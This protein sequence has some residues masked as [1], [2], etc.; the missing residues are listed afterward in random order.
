MLKLKHFSAII[1]CLTLLVSSTLTTNIAAQLPNAVAG[2]M[3]VLDDDGAWCWY[4]DE[5]AIIVDDRHVLIGAV[6]AGTFDKSRLG[7]INI[8]IHDLKE[9]STQIVEL[10]DQLEPDDHDSPALL[11]RPDGRVL[12]VYSM[13]GTD[14][15]IRWRWTKE[16]GNLLDWHDEQSMNGNDGRYNVSYSNVEHLTTEGESGVTY[17]FFRGNGWN[18]TYITSTDGGETWSQPRPFL[19]NDGR[20]Y[21]RYTSNDVDTIHVATSEQHPRNYDNSIYHGFIRAGRLHQTDGNVIASLDDAPLAVTELTRVFQGSPDAVAWASD[22]RLDQVGHPVIVY[23][24]QMNSAGLPA[25]QGGEDCRYRYARWDG[26]NWV[27]SNVAFAGQRLYAGEDDYTGLITLDPRDPS[28]VYF[29]TNA[30]PVTGQ[31]LISK[32]DQQRHYELYRGITDDLGKTWTIEPI[33]QHSMVN[34]LRPLVAAPTGKVT[35]ESKSML[36]WL[37]GTYET[38]RKFDQAVVGMVLDDTVAALQPMQTSEHPGIPTIDSPFDRALE[39]DAIATVAAAVAN[40]QINHDSRHPRWDWTQGAYYVGLL[41]WA[42]TTHDKT[43]AGVMHERFEGMK[44]SLGPRPLM[45]DDHCIGYAHQQLA[46]LDA[47]LAELDTITA[48]M[49]HVLEQSQSES[50]EWKDGIWDRE[51]AWC[52]ALFMAP[53]TLANMTTLTGNETYLQRADRLWWKTTDYLY[54]P[55]THLFYRDQRYFNQQTHDGKAVHWSRGN[56][57]VVGGLVRMLEI[58]PADHPGRHRY[59]QLLNE[60]AAALKELQTEDGYWTSNLLSPPPIAT[61]ETSGTAFFC[62]ALAWGVNHGVLDHDT[63]QPVIKKAWQGL[64]ATVH[65]DGMIGWVQRAADKP[66]SAGPEETEVYATGGFLLAAAEVW[67][68]VMMDSAAAVPVTILNDSN[69]LMLQATVRFDWADIATQLDN[70]TV[71][72]LALRDTRRGIFLPLQIVIS[73]ETNEPMFVQAT[74]NMA[75]GES[76]NLQW[77]LLDDTGPIRAEVIGRQSKSIVIED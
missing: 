47:D 20:P 75:A 58:L 30:D 17:N 51:W 56:G 71:D 63:Y 32:A 45:A 12:A 64:V 57:W 46:M 9:N 7:D 40:W 59:E 41:H 54:N 73:P 10:H 2:E 53:P 44:W 3:R 34:N 77:M 22:I 24:V 70:A 35:D 43:L 8:I 21:P 55:D 29:S 25:G 23:S 61:P 67:E 31:P 38:Y 62:Y 69:Q 52:D 6:S 39:P 27:D 18:P 74:L 68:M 60:M 28:V 37:R 16:P 13:H 19:T 49:N 33:T 72:N 42:T 66:G 5:R 11:L 65:E 36:I 50:L 14:N 48:A 1:S 4:E 26:K 15:R 76:C